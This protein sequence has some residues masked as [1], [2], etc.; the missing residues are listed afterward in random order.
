MMNTTETAP[1]LN[2]ALEEEYSKALDEIKQ[3]GEAQTHTVHDL[4]SATWAMRKLGELNKEDAEARKVVQANID[5]LNEWLQHSLEARQ[6]RRNYLEHEVLAYVANNRKHDPKFKLDTPYGKVS[7]TVKRKATPAISDETQVLNFIKSNWNK[8]EQTQVIK[9][10][11]KILV[12]E[13]KKQVTV[14]G[15]K[16]IDEDGQP[17]PGMHVDPAGTETP[18]IKPIQMTEALS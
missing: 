4:G 18:H 12:S 16:V 3:F 9:R 17:I 15:D 7:F 2:P 6:S 13:L 14:A 5:Q 11:E 10:T 1:V 8:S